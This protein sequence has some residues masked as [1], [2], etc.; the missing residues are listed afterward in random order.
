ML[1]A[2]QSWVLTAFSLVPK[3]ALM[4]R[5]CLIHL[6]DWATYYPS[7]LSLRSNNQLQISPALR[8]VLSGGSAALR[9]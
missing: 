4:R 5:C 6:N 1:M 3:K 8:L 2:I 9:A 7:T